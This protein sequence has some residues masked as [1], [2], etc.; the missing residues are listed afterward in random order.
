MRDVSQ[1]NSGA[2][3]SFAPISRAG[4]FAGYCRSESRLSM[5]RSATFPLSAHGIYSIQGL[6]R[7]IRLPYYQ[8]IVSIPIQRKLRRIPRMLH[9]FALTSEQR[10]PSAYKTV[11]T[12]TSRTNILF[13]Q[14]ALDNKDEQ[15]E[16][17]ALA[18][19]KITYLL[20]T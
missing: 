13:P 11:C 1:F 15:K 3:L 4:I 6:A 10:I 18:R 19:R 8:V 2:R 12:Q 16:S 20:R 9:K 5:L 14:P 17:P 7:T